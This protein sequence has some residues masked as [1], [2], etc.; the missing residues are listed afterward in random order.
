[1]ASEKRIT[2]FNFIA[3]DWNLFHVATNNYNRKVI[4]IF[5]RRA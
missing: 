3:G 2:K 1:M 4:V 5:K